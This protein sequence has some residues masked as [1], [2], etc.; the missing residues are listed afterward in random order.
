MTLEIDIIVG[1][2]EETLRHGSDPQTQKEKD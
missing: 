2:T 1:M